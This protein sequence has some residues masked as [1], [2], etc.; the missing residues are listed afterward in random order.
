LKWF[1]CVKS[2]E[3]GDCMPYPLSLLQQGKQQQTPQLTQRLMMTP[4]MQQAI[5]LLQAP[6][7]ELTQK[8]EREMEGNPVLEYLEEEE[9]V[10]EEPQEAEDL[11]EISFDEGQFDILRQLDEEFRDHFAESEG[12][13]PKR[14]QEEDKLK[15][16]LENSIEQKPSLF[17]HLMQ[18]AREESFSPREME[19]AEVI[20]GH[21]DNQGYLKTPVGEISQYFH[22]SEGE[23]APVLEKIR[24]FDPPGVAARDLCDVLKAQLI[25]KGK[26][27][28]LAYAI[29]DG[30]F[31]DLLHNRLPQIQKGLK[32]SMEDIREAIH[33]EIAHLN[34]HPCSHYNV[35]ETPVMIPDISLQ[36][37]ND[38]LLSVVNDGDLQPLRLNRKYL[39]MLDDPTVAEETKRFIKTKVLSAKWLLKNIDQRGDTLHRIAEWIAKEQRAFFLAPDGK[40]KPKTMKA[41]AEDLELHESTVARAVAN[42][43]I[44]TPRGIFPVR[45]FFSNAYTDQQ[46]EDISSKTVKQLLKK[47]IDEEDKKKPLSDEA[48]S[49]AIERRGIHC[50]RRTVA[51]YR[52]ELNFGTAQ[53]RR[54]Y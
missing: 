24:Q 7:M 4:Q 21:L 1:R 32:A 37:E 28:S 5:E 51:K 16:F 18:Q 17:E 30:Y 45:F 3:K 52:Q 48:L 27:E 47:L 42:K 53:Q 6:I 2:G 10:S 40:L 54:N 50:A 39:R 19:I 20:F 35:E 22:F 46:G 25:Y 15:V 9:E 29:V 14:S 26:K 13:Q 36:L 8:I 23:I 41:L 44:D 49:Q 34:L 43:V 12:Y 33:G 11:E 31:D 38:A